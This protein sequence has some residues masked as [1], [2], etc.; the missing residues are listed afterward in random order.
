MSFQYRCLPHV[1]SFAYDRSRRAHLCRAMTMGVLP[2]YPLALAAGVAGGGKALR[3][4]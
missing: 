2:L 1:D 4:Q 3:L